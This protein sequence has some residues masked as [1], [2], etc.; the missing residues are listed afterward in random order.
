MPFDRVFGKPFQI[1]EQADIAVVHDAVEVQVHRG[2][3][4]G[5]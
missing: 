5:R 4:V 1:L 2:G 3:N